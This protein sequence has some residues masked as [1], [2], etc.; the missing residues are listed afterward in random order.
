MAHSV[1]HR[2]TPQQSAY[3]RTGSPRYYKTRITK[4]VFERHHR[5]IK[6]GV[7]A[8]ACTWETQPCLPEPVRLHTYARFTDATLRQQYDFF[9]VQP[10]WAQLLT[11]LGP[12]VFAQLNALIRPACGPDAGAVMMGVRDG[13]PLTTLPVLAEISVFSHC[14]CCTHGLESSSQSVIDTVTIPYQEK[15]SWLWSK[16]FTLCQCVP[17]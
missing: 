3:R 7:H 8:H 5:L 2:D 9:S 11:P 4:V 17:S 1:Q 16:V 10:P 12:S 6:P 13:E 15:I 14:H